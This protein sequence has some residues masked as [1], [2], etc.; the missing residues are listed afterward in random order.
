MQWVISY[1]WFWSC[2]HQNGHA[3]SVGV[4]MSRIIKP[5]H[6]RHWNDNLVLALL[7][8]VILPNNKKGTKVVGTDAWRRKWWKMHQIAPVGTH[9]KARK[10]KTRDKIK[11][12]ACRRPLWV[13]QCAIFTSR[14]LN[15]LFSKDRC[16]WPKQRILTLWQKLEHW[17]CRH[18]GTHVKSLFTSWDKPYTGKFT[19]K[20]QYPMDP[21]NRLL[22]FNSRP[23]LDCFR[24]RFLDT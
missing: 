12:G 8:F 24:T 22:C 18:Q 21:R 3:R 14:L 11:V 13:S 9:D 5:R 23:V 17:I 4:V 2:K 19:F 7:G 6:C 10:P 15:S 20:I 16:T 1:N